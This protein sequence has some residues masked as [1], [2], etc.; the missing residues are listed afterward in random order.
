MYFKINGYYFLIGVDV[1]W[2]FVDG[3]SV[4]LFVLSDLF[5]FIDI[6][7]KVLFILEYFL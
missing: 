2:F 1:N 6:K 4:Y 7:N 5:C 3:V